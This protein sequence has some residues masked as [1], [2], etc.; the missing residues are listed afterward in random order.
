M[1][2]NSILR[3]TKDSI[4]Y[5]LGSAITSFISIALVPL[6]TR[7]FSPAEYGVIDLLVSLVF[8]A[9][10][11]LSYGFDTASAIL[12]FE[13]EHEEQRQKVLS[14]SLFFVLGVSFIVAII[15]LPFGSALSNGIFHT[16]NFSS[17][18]QFSF[19]AIPF[20]LLT[21][22]A[23]AALR[24]R[25]RKGR[26]ILTVSV[27][28]VLTIGLTTVFLLAFPLGVTG[29]FLAWFLAAFLTALFV[30]LLARKNFPLAFSQTT[31]R[32]LLR[33]GLPLVPAG[34]A[35]WSLSLIDRLFLNGFSREVLG[36]YSLGVKIS[37]VVGL[38]VAALQLAWS[39][40]ALSLAKQP[41]AKKIYAKVLTLFTLAAGFLALVLSAF[42]PEL[43]HLV[44]GSA[45]APAAKVV[46]ILS[47]GLIAY[48]SYS[49]VAIAVNVAKKT[50]HI[51]W[52]TTTAAAVNIVLN[53][54]LIPRWGMFGAA[55]ATLFAYVLSTWLLFRVGQRLYPIPYESRK[56]LMTWG[57]LFAGVASFTLMPLAI[58]PTF[59]AIKAALLALFLL[60]IVVF[61]ILEP[62]EILDARIRIRTLIDQLMKR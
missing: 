54:F 10:V 50:A 45:F 31:I 56:V 1:I 2:G 46:G 23:L 25:F 58:S 37:S 14:S 8:L 42:A 15:L 18:I 21:G 7:V 49:I 29:Y 27:N 9:N 41:E 19:A 36:W 5:G 28:V 30:F 13:T 53:I 52:T 61:R 62:R 22:F 57:L 44:S 43:V 38:A 32:S 4:I 60:L 47:L 16:P 26:Y 40:F 3:L 12:F 20:L 34:L 35:G 11:L 59:L 48:G 33:L 17:A 51:S 24:Y 6:L 39:P 55:I